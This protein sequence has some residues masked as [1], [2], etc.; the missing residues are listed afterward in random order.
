MT[1]VNHDLSAGNAQEYD[2]GEMERKI[3]TDTF[4]WESGPTDLS[5]HNIKPL[6]MF[7]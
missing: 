7:I 4:V 6:L 3:I 1:F 2:N 5:S